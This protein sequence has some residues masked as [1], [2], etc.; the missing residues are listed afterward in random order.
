MEVKLKTFEDIEPALVE[1]GKRES[2]IAKKEAEMNTKIQE[3]KDKFEQ[4]T[5][6]QRSEADLIRTKI[7]D[8]CKSN[9]RE[10]TDK[11]SKDFT[12]GVIGF[13]TNPPKVILLNKKYNLKTAIELLKKVFTGDYVRSK[14]EIDKEKILSDYA[15]EKLNDDKLAAVGLR[16]DQDESFYVDIKWDN[17][18]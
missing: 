4:D 14:E 10:F 15:S 12:H 8:F 1:L 6:A 18:Q 11:K 3:V 5:I 7:T 17:L 13:R 16:V 9:S 2:F